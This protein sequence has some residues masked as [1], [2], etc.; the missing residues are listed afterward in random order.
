MQ[1]QNFNM[2]DV[3]LCKGEVKFVVLSFKE[4]ILQFLRTL[5]E[6]SKNLLQNLR[7]PNFDEQKLKP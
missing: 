5:K 1:F 3:K 7:I 6:L 2:F 4:I